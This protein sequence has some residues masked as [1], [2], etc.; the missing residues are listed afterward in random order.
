MSS[1]VVKINEKTIQE[2]KNMPDKITYAVA[3]QTLD[4]VGS[5]KITP[6]KTGKIEI[7]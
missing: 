2:L 3:R 4:R 6:Y 7:G 1:V 5:A